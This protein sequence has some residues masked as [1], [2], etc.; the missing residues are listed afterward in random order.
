MQD[1]CCESA[2]VV[3]LLEARVAKMEHTAMILRA[4][5]V[6]CCNKDA[7]TAALRGDEQ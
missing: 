1:I 6:A 4:S 3:K 7:G 5:R 2:Q